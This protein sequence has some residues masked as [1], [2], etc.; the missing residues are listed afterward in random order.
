[1]GNML[2]SHHPDGEIALQPQEP[3]VCQLYPVSSSLLVTTVLDER[4]IHRYRARF[5][6][7]LEAKLELRL[8]QYGL[9]ARASVRKTVD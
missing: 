3:F 4:L 6:H 9:R 5:A 8:R 2:C 7:S 1:M